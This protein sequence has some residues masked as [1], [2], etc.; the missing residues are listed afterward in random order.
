VQH[1]S[2]FGSRRGLCERDGRPVVD[3]GDDDH[4]ETVKAVLDAEDESDE[5]AVRRHGY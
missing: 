5:T 4:P 2:R 1:V 3:A